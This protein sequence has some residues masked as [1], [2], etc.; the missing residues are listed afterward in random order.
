MD[1][2]TFYEKCDARDM[3]MLAI[4]SRDVT[5][6]LVSGAYGADVGFI[7]QALG[8]VFEQCAIDPDQI[9][10]AGFSDGASYA[11]S[12]GPTN[13]DLFRRIVAFSPGFAAPAVERFGT[14]LIWIS[15]G[16]SD[17]ILPAQRTEEVIVPGLLDLG[18]LV[19]YVPFDGGHEVPAE[20]SN[21]AL[22]W[23]IA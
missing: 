12:I 11:L 17:A 2:S 15:H 21:E 7:D 20:V 16:R 23:V 10:L 9:A 18:Y 13:G 14:P 1:W 4:E 22:D 5:W 8:L 19:T 6:D 3:I